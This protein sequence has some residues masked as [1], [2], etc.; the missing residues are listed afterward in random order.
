[1]RSDRPKFASNS[2]VKG[3]PEEKQAAV[4]GAISASARIRSTRRTKP[5]PFNLRANLER[6]RID[7]TVHKALLDTFEQ[8]WETAQAYRRL[9]ASELEPLADASPAAVIDGGGSVPT[10]RLGV[11][12][13][14]VQPSVSAHGKPVTE[15]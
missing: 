6:H 8:C 1:M 10:Q 11:E 2:R 13:K 4:H 3:T 14:T 9:V 7:I 5:S 12:T 15:T